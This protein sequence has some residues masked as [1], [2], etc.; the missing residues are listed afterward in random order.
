MTKPIEEEEDVTG[1]AS[2][3]TVNNIEYP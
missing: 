2:K 3:T 1:Y